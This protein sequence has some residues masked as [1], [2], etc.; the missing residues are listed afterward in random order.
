MN[1]SLE[2]PTGSLKSRRKDEWQP[3]VPNWQS[4]VQKDDWQFRN[5][6]KMIKILKSSEKRSNKIKTGQS[7]KSTHSLKQ[8]GIPH[9]QSE[10]I[11]ES[12]WN[13]DYHGPDRDQQQLVNPKIGISIRQNAELIK[14]R[15][16]RQEIIGSRPEA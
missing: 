5:T 14:D 13:R 15:T 4:E 1:G 8:K 11:P 3:R 12:A 9:L 2:F 6:S 7:K 10:A 16:S